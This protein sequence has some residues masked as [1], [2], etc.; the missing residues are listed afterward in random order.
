M[1]MLVSVTCG[2]L[3]CFLVVRRMALLGDAVSHAVLPGL[4]LA[5]VFSG[6]YGALAMGIGAVAAGLLSTVLIEGIHRNSRIKQDASLGIVLTA[7]FSLGVV[8]INLLA[9][10]AH[11][12][13]ECVLYGEIAFVPLQA[14]VDVLGLA[15]PEP[16]VHMAVVM[17]LIM[18]GIVLFYKELLITSF[19]PQ[20]AD[21]LGI[22][23]SRIHYG[24]M[25]A[26]SLTVVS[27]FESVGA[28]LVVAMLIVPGATAFLL[29][30]RL[31]WMLALAA[32][33]G[34]LSTAT[35]LVLAVQWD[36]SIAAAMVIA[37]AGLF[38]LAVIFSPRFGLFSRAF[39]R[40]QLR[41]HAAREGLHVA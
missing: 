15:V 21:S 41:N 3:G 37:G 36:C 31:H 19:D 22:R 30:S 34:F 8:L 16:V 39:R 17:L 23:S 29:A 11:L 18:L 9:G 35:G 6:S 28:I 1:G 12:D 33:H 13:Q 40:R 2:V 4:V 20:L 25:A 7:L 14:A 38:L 5:F 27:S 26:L 24:L 10:K 32:V